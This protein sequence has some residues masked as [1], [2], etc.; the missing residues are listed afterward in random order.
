MPQ[1]TVASNT[2]E[3]DHDASDPVNESEEIA[4]EKADKRDGDQTAS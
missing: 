4:T 3:E 2:E 1:V